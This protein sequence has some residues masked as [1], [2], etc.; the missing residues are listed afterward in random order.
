MPEAG[1]EGPRALVGS[2][3]AQ[4]A[5]A[6]P[7][8]VQCIAWPEGWLLWV[9]V[10][11]HG[12]PRELKA[13]GGGYSSPWRVGNWGPLFPSFKR[14]PP[15][16]PCLPAPASCLLPGH[17]GQ[18]REANGASTYSLRGRPG[19]WGE[20]RCG[21]GLCHRSG[22][23]RPTSP[24]QA[25]PPSPGIA[26]HLPNSSKGTSESVIPSLI[27]LSGL[28]T[29]LVPSGWTPSCPTHSPPDTLGDAWRG[30]L[31][32]CFHPSPQALQLPPQLPPHGED[33][34]GPFWSLG[35]LGKSP[36]PRTSF[37]LTWLPPGRP[38]I[39][40]TAFLSLR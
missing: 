27:L 24:P 26:S 19:Y 16:P 9:L 38:C 37:S 18:G 31:A 13:G 6:S 40:S 30:Y 4:G 15:W 33:G 5:R 11:P 21:G 20:R 29:L 39:H 34:P 1:P 7:H 8:P 32:S 25:S 14:V 10:S 17:R 23:P 3:W 12:A 2:V 22:S 36:G 28:E 35:P